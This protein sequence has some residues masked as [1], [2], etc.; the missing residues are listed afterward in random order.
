MCFSQVYVQWGSHNS[1]PSVLWGGQLPRHLSFR[2][3]HKCWCLLSGLLHYREPIVG[4]TWLFFGTC[5]VGGPG[6]PGIVG[7]KQKPQ[8]SQ[9]TPW[10]HLIQGKARP[11]MSLLV[12]PNSW[13]GP[14]LEV[15]ARRQTA[16]FGD[17]N[18][19]LVFGINQGNNLSR[20]DGPLISLSLSFSFCK[21]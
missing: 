16:F 15:N 17:K 12:Q 4:S 19:F 21:L 18:A 9:P 3:G 6:N 5:W 1:L 13:M 2:P 11:H 8:V 20:D 7:D 10:A 14:I